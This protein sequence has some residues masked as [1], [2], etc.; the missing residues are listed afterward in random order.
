MV[1]RL[2]VRDC[3]TTVHSI[4]PVSDCN[5]NRVVCYVQ[6]RT[7]SSLYY[8]VVVRWPTQPLYSQSVGGISIWLRCRHVRYRV[9]TMI[10]QILA[11]D[12]LPQPIYHLRRRSRAHYGVLVYSIFITSHLQV[13][14]LLLFHSHH[15]GSLGD[16]GLEKGYDR[17]DSPVR[18]SEG[19]LCLDHPGRVVRQ[20]G[21]IY[22][23]QSQRC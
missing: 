11:L 6:Y 2:S 19:R 20:P 10:L 1:A 4:V 14:L 8:N 22:P 13:L 15:R 23:T 17:P 12:W 7:L 16:S 9:V 21:C 18:L 5:C 3:D